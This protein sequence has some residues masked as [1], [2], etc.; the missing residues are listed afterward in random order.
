MRCPRAEGA[1]SLGKAKTVLC[2]N[3]LADETAEAVATWAL[4]INAPAECWG[5]YEPQAGIHTL[6]QPAMSALYASREPGELLVQLAQAGGVNPEA[7]F[8]AAS[9][10]DSCADAARAQRAAGNNDD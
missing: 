7:A 5:D 1:E 2:L 6:Q 9:Y 8:G 4:P 3:T 10:Y